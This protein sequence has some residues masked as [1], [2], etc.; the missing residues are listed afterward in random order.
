[1]LSGCGSSSAP[2]AQYK[3]PLTDSDFAD[4]FVLH[5]KNTYYA[6]ATTAI[7]ENFPT[8]HSRD[9]IHWKYGNDAMPSLP[10]WAGG[11]SWAPEVMPLT[12]GRY[13]L[14]FTAMDLGSGRQCLGRATGTKPDGPFTDPSSRPFLCQVDLGGD[15]DPDP[16]KDGDGKT[17]LLWKNDGNCCGRDTFIFSQRMSADGAKMMGKPA[18]LIHEEKPWEY[19]V[20]EA[21]T[22][23]KHDGKY[24]LFF[25]GNDFGMDLYA[26]G[27]A[28]CKGPLGPCT[29]AKENPILKSRCS[30]AGPGGQTIVT[31]KAGQDW[32]LYAAWPK[33][34]VGPTAGG[35]GREL[36]M[37]K[38]TWK[39]GKPVVDGPTCTRQTAPST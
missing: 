36:W 32:I 22:M 35:P 12:D 14:Y 28:T 23:W 10:G 29:Q 37:D 24:Y 9:L 20:V 6:Y 39:D 13:V 2:Q 26:V 31:D 33:S 7:S 16:F 27:Y 4:P 8:M 38:L 11:S 19:D 34:A 18:Q 17:Y 30:A 5:V 15:I 21:P 1:M 3:N 25:S